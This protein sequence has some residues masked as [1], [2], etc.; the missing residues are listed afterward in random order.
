MCAVGAGSELGAT[1]TIPTTTP[2]ETIDRAAAFFER[3]GPVV[4]LGIGCFG[5]VDLRRG[6]ITTTPKPGWADTDV[7]GPLG[8][9]L[10]VPI[11]FDTDVN[12]AALG[13]HRFGAARGLDTFVY[14]TVGTGIGGGVIAGGRLVHGLSHPEI[15]HL[16]IPRVSGDGFAG[17]C[18]YHGD[19]FEGLASGPA[20]AARWGRPGEELAG[21]ERVWVLEARYVALGL[22]SLVATLSPELIVLGG[23]VGSAPGLLP[24]V[25]AVM[26]E[27][28]GGYM[29]GPPV[30][31]PGLGAHSGV[32]GALA[33]AG[34]R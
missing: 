23:G 27:L 33:L 19:C 31:A 7:A 9:R 12:A 17:V 2:D 13:E 21:D 8:A 11:A 26:E 6:R 5:P 25:E 29:E 30:V 22:A 18:P 24:R 32:V 10:G 3:E 4:A 16:R 15:G 28:L 20:L 34:E 1:D 14:V